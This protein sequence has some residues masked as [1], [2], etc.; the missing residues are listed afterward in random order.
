MSM[1]LNLLSTKLKKYREQFQVSVSELAKATGIAEHDLLAFER[2]EKIPT[3]DEILILA[4]F[5]LCDFR[6]FVTNNNIAPIEQT[7]LLF[8][9]YGNELSKEDRWA[10]QE[11][12]YLSE[13]EAFLWEQLNLNKAR[14]F[15]YNKSG[16]YFKLQGIN[17]AKELRNFFD[18][19]PHQIP[20]NIYHD[21]RSLGLHIFRRKLN[22]SNISGICIK[23]PTIGKCVL[24][25][26]DEDVFRQRFTVAHEVG[27]CILDDNEDIIVS[28]KKWSKDNLVE[29]RAN[30]FAAN[31]LLPLEYI[32]N[33]PNV[34]TWT[35][36]KAI[37]WAIKLKVS[38]AALGIALSNA[39]LISKQTEDMI[40]SVRIPREL[41]IDPELEKSLSP[42]GKERMHVL[43]KKGLSRE[44]VNLCFTARR[45]NIISNSRLAEMLLVA[46]YE[47]QEIAKIFGEVGHF[48]D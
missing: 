10:I 38:P 4:D 46:E 6:F 47:L 26:Y 15:S 21:F 43:L 22:N 37:E 48:N 5:Y 11:V 12:L 42:K 24:V 44:Y 30:A 17:A 25:N 31:Y 3:G 39:D 23:H 19:K 2:A 36:E 34:G 28:Y 27:H 8:R 41:K 16:N 32:K 45:N 7:E 35:E 14:S 1:D 40:K 29:I 33:I 20:L 18:Y 13:C 9:R